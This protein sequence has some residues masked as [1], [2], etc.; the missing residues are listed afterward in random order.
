[1][2]KVRVRINLSL[3]Q[4]HLSAEDKRPTSEAE[5]RQFLLDSGFAPE[6]DAWI[7]EEKDLGQVDPSEVVEVERLD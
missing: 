1:M 6:G 4:A 2:A 3:L 5:V 7:V